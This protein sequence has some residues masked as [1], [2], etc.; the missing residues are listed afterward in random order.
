MSHVS[1]AKLVLL[2]VGSMGPCSFPS[3]F[4][5]VKRQYSGKVENYHVSRVLN[6]LIEAGAVQLYETGESFDVGRNFRLIF[7]KMDAVK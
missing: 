7:R 4:N 6:A 1:I 3:I 5:Y 2:Q